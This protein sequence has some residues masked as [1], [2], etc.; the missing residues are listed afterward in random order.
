MIDCTLHNVVVL[1]SDVIAWIYVSVEPLY[2]YGAMKDLL[3]Q[4]RNS[5]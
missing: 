3:N 2:D 4:I 1:F 5:L